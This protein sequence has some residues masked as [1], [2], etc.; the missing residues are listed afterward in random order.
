MKIGCVPYGHAKPLAAA[1]AGREPVWAHPTAL[2]RK[3]WAGEVD[4]ALVPVWEVL[5]QPGT[6]VLDG[7]AIGS[8]GEVRSVGVF[9]DL[10]LTEC[11]TIRITPHSATSVQLWKLVAKHRGLR[12]EP[13][14]TAEARLLIGDEALEEWKRRNGHGMLD[15]GQA[16]TDWTGKPFVFAVW[17]FGPRA[18]VSRKEVELFRQRCQQGIARRADLA[19]DEKEEEYLTRCIRYGLGAEEK[20]GLAEFARRSGL[21]RV[22]IEWL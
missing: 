19:G 2:A 8:R 22:K 3:L 10:P 11:R 4:L 21:G 16:W 12:L 9:H 14:E 13:K 15:L 5:A 20:E 18:I 17:A 1:W 7:V 6:R